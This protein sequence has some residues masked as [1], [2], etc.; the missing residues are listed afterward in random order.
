MFVVPR[1]PRDSTEPHESGSVLYYRRKQEAVP[2]VCVCNLFTYLS[3]A[4]Q[5]F[6]VSVGV[7][8][9]ESYRYKT[10][11]S[12]RDYYSFPGGTMST[13]FISPLAWV[14]GA[15]LGQYTWQNSP[16]TVGPAGQR[17][18]KPERRKFKVACGGGVHR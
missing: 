2:Y 13:L 11:S 8:A 18:H 1:A 12:H 15:K 6:S 7:Y 10:Q 17:T 9:V 3:Q 14:L 4:G 5:G 16:T